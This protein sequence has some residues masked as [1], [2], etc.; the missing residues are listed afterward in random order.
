MVFN[1][2]INNSASISSK[3]LILLVFLCFLLVDFY[4]TQAGVNTLLLL[5]FSLLALLFLLSSNDWFL[6]FL[7]IE[8]LGLTSYC[9]V[10]SSRTEKALEASIK[11]FAV[12]GLSASFLLFG[13]LLIYFSTETTAFFS[14]SIVDEPALRALTLFILSAFL[15]KLG[16]APFH[17]W[18]ADVYEGAPAIVTVFLSVI[19]KLAIFLVL[20]SLLMSPLFYTLH[21]YRPLFVLASILSIVIGCFGAL[22]QKKIKRLLAYS[23]INN[24]GY[25]L[26]GLSIGNLS[27]LQAAST[28]LVFYCFSLLLLF[29]LILNCKKEGDHNITY[30]VDLKNLRVGGMLTPL[31]CTLTLFS[32][33]GIPPLTG[34]WIKFFIL[35]ELVASKLYVIATIAAFASVLSSFY[36]VSLIKILYFE[37]DNL[38]MSVSNSMGPIQTLFVCALAFTLIIYII[39]PGIV[40]SYFYSLALTFFTPFL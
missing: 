23:S 11:Y 19:V 15:L 3:Q 22:F 4:V 13:I 8:L 28:Y 34:F 24:V 37:E 9:L 16:A 10:A 33:A 26:A 20:V 6:L 18:V 35:N 39:A 14:D 17:Y 12:G 29:T 38:D 1:L 2:F 40:D 27:G 30:I 31:L 32:F 25:V 36:Y 5:G 7:S 21:I